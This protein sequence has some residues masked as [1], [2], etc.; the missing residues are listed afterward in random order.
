MDYVLQMKRN[1]YS[2][3]QG[4]HV[5]NQHLDAKLVEAR[6]MQDDYGKRLFYQRVTIYILYTDNSFQTGPNQS[7]LACI[8]NKMKRMGLK[9]TYEDGVDNFQG[10]NVDYK[11]DGTILFMQPH[12]IQLILGD[13]YLDADIVTYKPTPTLVTIPLHIFK[14]EAA[15][16][17]HHYHY[18][19]VIGKLN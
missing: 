7:Q 5:W 9:L 8:I 13:L 19:S 14:S 11:P 10:V 17:D 1:Y 3:K 16:F 12:L 18:C 4:G 6:F 15:P 2:Q